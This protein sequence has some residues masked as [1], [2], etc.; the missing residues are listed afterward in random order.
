MNKRN[1]K[2]LGGLGYRVLTPAAMWAML[3]P[4][5]W[6]KTGSQGAD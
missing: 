4:D 2:K 1:G 6:L 5:N 3:D